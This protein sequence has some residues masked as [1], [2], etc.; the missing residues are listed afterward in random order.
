MRSYAYKPVGLYT[1]INCY[2]T[3]FSWDLIAFQFIYDFQN[4]P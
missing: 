4:V 1:P 3:K 2:F